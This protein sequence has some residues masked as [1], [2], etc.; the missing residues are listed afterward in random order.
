MLTFGQF[1]P[2]AIDNQGVVQIDGARVRRNAD[3]WVT[4]ASI[5]DQ[6]RKG[7]LA[8]GGVA[9]VFAAH[10]VRDSFGKVVDADRELIGPESVAVADGKLAALQLGIF[11]EV[12]KTLVVPVNYFVW[13]DDAQI[14]RFAAGKVLRAALALVNDFAGFADRV[15]GLQLLAAAGA[16][17]YEPFGG[18]LVEDF[19]EKIEV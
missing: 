15:F 13:N 1:F 19:L 18:E 17:I 9:N 6:L 5:G 10:N 12:S 16:G 7:D 11:A 2:G 4:L 14:V 8:G 3:I